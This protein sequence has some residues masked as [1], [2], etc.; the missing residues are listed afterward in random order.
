LPEEEEAEFEE[1]DNPS[2]EVDDAFFSSKKRSI[3]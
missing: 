3:N 1:T 2:A